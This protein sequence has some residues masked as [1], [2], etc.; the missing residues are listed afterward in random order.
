MKILIA[1]DSFKGALPAQAVCQAV[2][3]GL[4]DVWPDAEI[5]LVPMAD[6]GEG[7]VQALVS[8]TGGMERSATVRGPLQG[9]LS[10]CFGLLG[11]GQTAVIEMAAASGLPLVPSEQR[12][13]LR[14]TT[15]GTGQLIQAALDCGAQRLI[16]GIGGS[17]TVDSGVGCAQAVG[18]RFFDA[19]ER[20]L[21]DGLAGG[22]LPR[23][24][25]ID[26]SQALARLQAV[27]ILVACD[28]NNP[29]CGP[30]GAAAVFGPQKGATPQMVEQ[31]D[32][33]LSHLAELIGR[34][35][36]LS[37]ADLPGAGAAGGLG[38]GLVA[39]CGAQLKP[40]VDIVMAQLRLAERMPGCDL[41]ITGEGRL[42]AQS[43]MGKTVSGVGQL[44]RKLGVP[45]VALAGS[46]GPDAFRALNVIDAYLCI[47]DGPMSLSHAMDGTASMLRATAA[48]LAR[49]WSVA[50]A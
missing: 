41:V 27:Q 39:F 6:G 16:I 36:G 13:P 3:D 5:E 34:D 40:G 32:A 49:I 50:R 29:L 18:V 45:V 2:A 35:L 14:T 9:E 46:I 28:V 37:I 20:L 11:D 15:F 24:A 22:D 19:Q 25:R 31:L 21:P 1:A 43:V 12:D 30:N 10:A 48:N 42:D 47:L 44:A 8:A 33:G 23:I 26:A 4:C 7:T 38:A 17:A